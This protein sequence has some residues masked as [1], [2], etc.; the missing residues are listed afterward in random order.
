MR[1]GIDGSNLRLG[2]GVTHLVQVLEA[3]EPARYGVRHVTVWGARRLLDALPSRR[4]LRAAHEPALEGNILTRFH[5]Q[6][7]QL[8]ARAA[9]TCDLLFSPGGTYLGTFRPFVTM[10][11]NMLPFDGA[12]RRRYGVSGMGLRL[13]LLRA[14]QAATFRRA[15]GV[16]LLTDHAARVLSRVVRIRGRQ[17]VIPYGVD[18]RFLRRPAEQPPLTAFSDAHPFRWLYVS[19]IHPYKHPWHVVE[20]VATLRASGAPVSLEV[21]G[22]AYAASADRLAR[23]IRRLDPARQFITVSPARPH[24]ELPALYRSAHGFVFASTCENMPNTLLEAMAAGLPI[25][26]SNRLPMPDFPGEGAA[27]FDAEDPSSIAAAL[28][29]LLEEPRLRT[30]LATTAWER[31]QRYSWERSAHDTF[32]F[33]RQTVHE[34]RGRD[35]LAIDGLGQ[36]A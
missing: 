25:A 27:Y 23:T 26:C 9:G 14:A 7:R 15:D 30:T 11:Q 31:A 20:A 34:S 4:W 22:P 6:Q 32:E 10:F 2:G 33:L 28:W 17:T 35:P 24:R 16:I 29:R 8:T 18:R 12:E 19:A 21:V 5:W 36:S 13:A 1:I 3:A